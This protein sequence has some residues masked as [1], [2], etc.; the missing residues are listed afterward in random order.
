MKTNFDLS[1]LGTPQGLL[2]IAV[3]IGFGIL[4][5]DASGNLLQR[6]GEQE[7]LSH[8]YFIPLISGWL[9]WSNRENVLKS[10]GAPTNVGFIFISGACALAL[11]GQLVN[12]HFLQH[13]GMISAIIGAILLYGGW[14]LLRIV[15][16]PVAFLFFAIPPPHWFMTV[17]SWKFQSISS[18]IGVWML[19]LVDVPVFLSGNIIDLGNYQLLV[20]EACSGLRYLFPF[21]SLGVMSAYLYRGPLWH[22]LTIVAV[23]VPI[24]IILNSFRIAVTGVLVKTYGTQHA[25]GFLHFFEGWVVF[26]MCLAALYVVVVLLNLL[27]KP[28]RSVFDALGAPILDPVPPSKTKSQLKPIWTT[29]IIGALVV[30][31]LIV[32]K[33][34]IVDEFIAPDRKEFVELP[35]EFRDWRHDV[36]PIDG[37]VADILGADDSLVVNLFSPDDN[38]VF[39]L[40]LAY[41]EER[42]DGSTWHSPRQ[43][44]PGGGWVIEDHTIVKTTASDGRPFAYNRL[45]IQNQDK[46]QLVYYWYDQRGRKM[47]DE[48][49]MK[50]MTVWDTVVNHRSDG[51]L[52][53]VLTP[54][55]A[56]EPIEAADQRLQGFIDELED[57]LPE[58]VPQ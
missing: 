31:A 46:R 42:Q 19:R 22:K 13:I 8:S 36:Q 5:W 44:I 56:D 35:Y 53:R 34:V 45:I 18:I 55:N 9:V 54:L 47:A 25:E 49:V 58:Y 26:I 33:T 17:L 16:A 32:S 57:V 14:S 20:A 27:S 11:I 40:Y 24:T 48:F 39:N 7:E 10:I 28:K 2:T 21:L 50:I 15:A 51:A 4:F 30:L 6:W 43:C 29:G 41:L 12:F 23:T 3:L 37:A 1:K 52:I 38:S